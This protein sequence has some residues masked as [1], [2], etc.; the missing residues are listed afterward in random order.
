MKDWDKENNQ[1]KHQFKSYYCAGCKQRKPC[2]K[3]DHQ[4]CCPCQFQMEQEK[5][6]GYNSYEEVLVS[7]QI[8]WEKRLRQL[9]LLRSYWGCKQCRGLVVDAYSLYEENRL[10]CQ[11]YRM[12]KEGSASSPIS[13]LEQS[14]W[15]KKRWGIDL[16]E[17]LE[18]ERVYSEPSQNFPQ[19]PVNKN[20]A[21]KWLK[22]KEHLSNCDCLEVEAKEIYLLFANSLREM[23]EKLNECACEISEKV[24]VSG[25]YYTWCE[26]CDKTIEVASKKRVVKN[27]NDPRFWG[28]ES[29]FKILCLRCIGKKFYKRMVDWQRK[30]FREYV[31]RGY[32]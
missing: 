18:R 26:S 21:E 3:L 32:V 5:A 25:D 19:L 4:Y 22:N 9:Q 13:F 11:P 2:G 8:D 16:A 15:Y 12:K 30:K 23:E 14:K 1:Q 7:K 29:E 24:R 20:C 27:R 17:W 6:Q 10:V 31:R 28:V